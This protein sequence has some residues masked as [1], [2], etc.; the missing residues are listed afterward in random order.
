MTESFGG[1]RRTHT[2]GVLRAGHAGQTV[3][4]MGWASRR[5]D[6]GGLI[7]VD[8][9]DREG[10]TQL[11]FNPAQDPAAHEVAGRIRVEFVLA[12]EG[13]V[14][15]RPP[16]TVN[17]NLA[18]GEIEVS[19]RRLRILNESKPLPSRWTSR[20]R[21]SSRSGSSIATSICAGR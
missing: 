13:T 14:E 10:L 7:F 21:R 11:V 18:T 16:G 4:L 12:V 9:R 1:M 8:L 20:R 17:A 2:C 6:H 5:R 19:V 3:T 15:R